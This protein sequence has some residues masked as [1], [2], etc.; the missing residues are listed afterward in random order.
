ME[1]FYNSTWHSVTLTSAMNKQQVFKHYWALVLFRGH[2]HCCHAMPVEWEG[3]SVELGL[4]FHL[5]LGSKGH[6]HIIW[7]V[8]QDPLP[9]ESSH[10]P[11][12]ILTFSEEVKIPFFLGFKEQPAEFITCCQLHLCFPLKIMFSLTFKES[13]LTDGL[14]KSQ[15]EN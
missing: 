7:L 13:F 12:N 5:Y 11:R 6:T 15:I 8:Q 3:S 1:I 14:G 4:P 2:G 10:W 9:V